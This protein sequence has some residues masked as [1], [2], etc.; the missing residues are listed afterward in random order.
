MRLHGDEE[1]ERI[2]RRHDRLARGKPLHPSKRLRCV[3]HN[4]RRL[5]Q[6][7]QRWEV[8][9]E[10]HFSVVRIVRRRHLHRASAERLVHKVV[11]KDRNGAINKRNDHPLP[12]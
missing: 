1:T 6:D 4:V 9:T 12:D 8:V 10:S 2:E 11:A 5:I 3:S 7:G